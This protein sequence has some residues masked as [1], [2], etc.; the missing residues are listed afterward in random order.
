MFNATWAT[1]MLVGL[2]TFVIAQYMVLICV[3]E[4]HLDH[5]ML[6]TTVVLITFLLQ[7]HLLDQFQH[8]TELAVNTC[9]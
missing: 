6:N 7:E 4:E 5:T 2:L 1:I 9:A 8:N 3:S